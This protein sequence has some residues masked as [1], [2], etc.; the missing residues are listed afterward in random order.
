MNPLVSILIPVYN[1]EQIVC[2]TIESAI[3]QTY[4]NTEIIIV[5][6]CSTDGTW[7]ILQK[8]TLKDRRI[9]IFQNAV[10]VGPVLNWKRCIDEAK[11][12]YS[13]ILFSDD[14][15]S[16]N[17]IEDTL[18]IFDKE[19]AFVLTS[20]KIFGQDEDSD[21]SKN[22]EINTEY[23]S[24]YY[25]KHVLVD[26]FHGFPDSPCCSIFRTKDLKASLITDIQNP[27]GLNFLRYGAGN[28][29]LIFLIT[30][31]RYSKIKT[32]NGSFT[33]FRS[34]ENSF[35]TSNNLGI[36]Y[37]FSRFYFIKN[38]C[39]E[40]TSMF[41]THLLL[42]ILNNRRKNPVYFL[43][44]GSHNFKFGVQLILKRLKSKIKLKKFF[45]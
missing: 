2:E 8:Y 31:T 23:S 7:S 24:S 25:L 10:N 22:F 9:K 32:T 6:N 26:N 34:H 29:L 37:D 30:A 14:I 4:S 11:G 18:S 20:V 43:L 40:Y 45:Y 15:I 21:Y 42:R 35:T 27:L 1:R 33:Y 13:K 28:D 17:F 39:T 36:Y 12:E 19:T 41:K 44:N 16:E 5:D 38:Y 3:N